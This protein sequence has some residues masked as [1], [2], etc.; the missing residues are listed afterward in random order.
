MKCLFASI[1][2]FEFS[3]LSHSL[4]VTSILKFRVTFD[5]VRSV[6]STSAPQQQDPF[7]IISLWQG[8]ERAPLHIPFCGT[9]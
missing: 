9:I 1:F 2:N 7:E 4:A 6:K 3:L 8:A 5:L